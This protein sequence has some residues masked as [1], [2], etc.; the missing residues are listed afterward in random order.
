M[1]HYTSPALADS[2]ANKGAS[3]SNQETSDIDEDEEKKPGTSPTHKHSPSMR[4]K[5]MGK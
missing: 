4:S 2:A 3:K 1:E 5:V